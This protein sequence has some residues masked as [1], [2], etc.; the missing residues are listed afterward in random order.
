MNKIFISLLCVTAC[1]SAFAAESHSRKGH[2]RNSDGAYV[3][4]S[5]ATN[6]NYTK[7][8]NYSQKGNVN[9][10]TGKNGTQK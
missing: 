9:P 8:D 10:Y 6:P 5:R 7:R 1:P 2:I 4:P 3:A